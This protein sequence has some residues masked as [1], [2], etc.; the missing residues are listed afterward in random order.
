[1]DAFPFIYSK[2]KNWIS[3]KTHTKQN[4]AKKKEEGNKVDDESRWKEFNVTLFHIFPC[5]ILYLK[6][7]K[8]EYSLHA[9]FNNF[10]FRIAKTAY[11]FLYYF[12]LWYSISIS[13]S[14]I[15]EMGLYNGNSNTS[16]KKTQNNNKDK[17][18]KRNALKHIVCF[19]LKMDI[20]FLCSCVCCIWYE[21]HGVQN[22]CIFNSHSGNKAIYFHPHNANQNIKLPT[23]WPRDS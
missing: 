2:K 5:S 18:L 1:M 13:Y 16:K 19:V 4:K 10:F 20:F 8:A 15:D 7:I 14:T 6:Q 23:K 11:C 17:N 9:H 12:F 22:F 21:Y 3:R